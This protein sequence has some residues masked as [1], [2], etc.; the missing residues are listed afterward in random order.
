VEHL[1]D[2]FGSCR[3]AGSYEI[4]Y[5]RI[6]GYCMQRI[7]IILYSIGDV[8]VNDG[9]VHQAGVFGVMFH[10]VSQPPPTVNNYRNQGDYAHQD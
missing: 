9:I 1:F 2:R 4:F 5:H 10:V 7:E 3:I 8:L 6:A